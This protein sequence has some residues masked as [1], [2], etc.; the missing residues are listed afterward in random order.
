MMIALLLTACL[1]EPAITTGAETHSWQGWIYADLPEE[2]TPGLE[3]GTVRL[4]DMEGNLVAEGTQPNEDRPAMWTVELDSASDVEV[5]ISGPEQLTTVWR[6]TTPDAQ[7]YWYS[8]SLFAAGTATM[9]AFWSDLAEITG[10]AMAEPG[11]THL[12]GEPVWV[13]PEDEAAWTGASVTVYDDQ[14]GVYPAITLTQ[15]EE[16]LLLPTSVTDGPISVFA[17]T[18]IVPGPVRLVVDSSDGRSA[19]V[20][21]N[22][23]PGELLSAFAFALPEHQ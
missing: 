17:V 13:R 3:V 12:L 9:D 19:V 1:P 20:D 4:W 11:G 15:D 7:A 6:T 8:G 5:R 10:D 23:G 18:N 14:G 22:A 16:G 2:D 21:Y